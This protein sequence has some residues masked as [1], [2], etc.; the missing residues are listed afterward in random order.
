MV[1]DKQM[2]VSALSTIIALFL[3]LGKRLGGCLI[4]CYAEFLRMHW[5]KNFG[6]WWCPLL[7]NRLSTWL[8]LNYNR[9]LPECQKDFRLVDQN[10]MV[11]T[12]ARSLASHHEAK[13]RLISPWCG[14]I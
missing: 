8:W 1:K 6:I 14:A 10:D 12:L 5:L 11:N 9:E 2:N 4:K 13:A 3:P 7:L